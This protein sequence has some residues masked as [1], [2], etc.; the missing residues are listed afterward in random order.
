MITIANPAEGGSDG[1]VTVDELGLYVK[2]RVKDSTAGQQHP[3]E[4]RQQETRNIPF[5]K[6]LR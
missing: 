6:V 1:V 5:A 4:T 3:V 2:E